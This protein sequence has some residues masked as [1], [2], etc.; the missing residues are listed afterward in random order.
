LTDDDLLISAVLDV[1]I[2]GALLSGLRLIYVLK[3]FFLKKFDFFLF[4]ILNQ[5]MFLV[6]LDY[7]NVLISKIIFL[8]FKK[9]F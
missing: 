6:F 9:L 8:N 2:V 3:V 1:Y 5:Y 4:F 7:F